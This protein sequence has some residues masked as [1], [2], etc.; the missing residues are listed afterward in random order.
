[1]PE[2]SGLGPQWVFSRLTPS[3]STGTGNHAAIS[4][5]LAMV[6]LSSQVR[7]EFS[8]PI[9]D[10]GDIMFL[11]R[12]HFLSNYSLGRKKSI[13]KQ[14]V[15]DWGRANNKVQQDEKRRKTLCGSGHTGDQ[16]HFPKM[17]DESPAEMCLQAPL[18]QLHSAQPR[19]PARTSLCPRT[20][21]W[22]AWMQTT[23]EKDQ[24]ENCWG[25]PS[26]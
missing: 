17:Q 24:G 19:A 25:G 12:G 13:Q 21:V 26:I 23:T 16:W 18:S 3:A 4:S 6:K 7:G 8:P 5:P 10:I 1:M 22:Q 11:T 15:R 20:E 14:K 9:Y 2:E